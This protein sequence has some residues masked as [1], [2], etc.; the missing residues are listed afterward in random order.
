MNVLVFVLATL[1]GGSIVPLTQVRILRERWILFFCLSLYNGIICT[2]VYSLSINPIPIIWFIPFHTLFVYLVVLDIQK[3]EVPTKILILLFIIG[4]FSS[5]VFSRITMYERII[6]MVL[7]GFP[8]FLLSCLHKNSIGSGDY[9]LLSILGF[10]FGVEA[11]VI[12][13][14]IAYA[15]A[16]VVSLVGCF[17]KR[18]HRKSKIAMYPYF[19][20]AL[21]FYIFYTP[22]FHQYIQISIQASM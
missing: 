6:A 8:L 21:L 3:K 16:L 20:L 5:I 12:V 13:M 4:I 22:W 9:I 17:Q 1:G 15:S 2:I 11:V 10:I 14:I 18:L 19:Y 7:G